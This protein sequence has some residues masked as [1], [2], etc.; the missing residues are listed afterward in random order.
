V[1]SS[2]LTNKFKRLA[3]DPLVSLNA[4][5]CE[6]ISGFANSRTPGLL[7]LAT[8]GNAVARLFPANPIEVFKINPKNRIKNKFFTQAPLIVSEVAV[9][10]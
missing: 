2:A 8:G 4:T 5:T 10:L 6:N 9:Q 3:N 1:Q 7:G